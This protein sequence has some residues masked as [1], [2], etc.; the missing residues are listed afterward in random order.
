M[1]FT[2]SIDM[3]NDAFTDDPN[4]EVARILRKTAQRIATGRDGG[5][6]MDANGNSVGAWE[7]K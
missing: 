4:A 3:D 5:F 2:L 1:E 7:I 6:A